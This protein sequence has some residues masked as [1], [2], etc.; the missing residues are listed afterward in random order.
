MLLPGGMGSTRFQGRSAWRLVDQL[1]AEVSRL[2]KRLPLDADQRLGEKLDEA[3]AAASRRISESFMTDRPQDSARLIRLAR[4][5]IDDV[6]EGIRL[7]LLKRVCVES[8]LRELREILS[9]LYPALSSSLAS[10]QS[11]TIRDIGQSS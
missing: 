1:R 6:Q 7:L 3:A 11:R 10:Q 4:A 8:D 9:R 5:S 2:I